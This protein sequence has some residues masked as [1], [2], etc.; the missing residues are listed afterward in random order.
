METLDRF[1]IVFVGFGEFLNNHPEDVLTSDMAIRVAVEEYRRKTGRE[2]LVDGW[3]NVMVVEA[4][5][6]RESCVIRL[7][8]AGADGDYGTRDDLTREWSFG[9]GMMSRASSLPTSKPFD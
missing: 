7:R 1:M 9:W 4:E 5:V 8:S 6:S 2:V 3:G